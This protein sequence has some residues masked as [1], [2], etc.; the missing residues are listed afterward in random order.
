MLKVEGKLL[1]TGFACAYSVGWPG[2]S[3]TT[4]RW[5]E[6][7]QCTTALWSPSLSGLRWLPLTPPPPSPSLPP[8][9]SI[10]QVQAVACT[11]SH[12]WLWLYLKLQYLLQ[13]QL[14]PTTSNP[15][16]PAIYCSQVRASGPSPLTAAFSPH[17]ILL[18]CCLKTDTSSCRN[19]TR[20]QTVPTAGRWC[21]WPSTGRFA[22]ACW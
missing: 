20:E 18:R 2:L 19:Q 3:S 8:P 17:P 10:Q 13:T 6:K 7:R 5:R 12:R 16:Y 14:D 9:L 22:L 11:V 4:K 15:A 1:Q 21:C